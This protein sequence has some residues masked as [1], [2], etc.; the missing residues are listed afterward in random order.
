MAKYIAGIDAGT[1]GT[2]ITVFSLDGTPAGSAYREYPCTY[3]SVG[4]VEQ[5]PRLLWKAVCETSKEVIAKT[6]ID[7]AEIGS[8]AIS[9]QRGTFFPVDR[10]WNPLQDSLVWSDSRALQEI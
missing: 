4:W 9:S 5:D 6:G 2:K 7:A 1:T 10:D 8:V 3:P